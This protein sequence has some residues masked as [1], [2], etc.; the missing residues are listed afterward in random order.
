MFKHFFK[1]SYMFLYFDVCIPINVFYL[2]NWL[3]AANAEVQDALSLDGETVG[4]LFQMFNAADS[5]Q[6]LP[7]APTHLGLNPA[8]LQ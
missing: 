7:L 6:S 8:T 3:L 1:Y 5:N 2:Q 4:N